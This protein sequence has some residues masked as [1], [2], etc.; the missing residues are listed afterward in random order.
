MDIAARPDDPAATAWLFEAKARPP[1]LTLP[2]LAATAAEALALADAPAEAG[3]LAAAFWPGP[4]TLVLRR[5]ERSRPW[6]LGGESS[7]IGLR[8]PDLALAAAFLSRTGPLAVTSANR[9]GRPPA[10]GRE[11]L[12]AVFGPSVAVYLVAA[13]GAAQDARGGGRPST[14]VDLSGSPRAS[15]RRAGTLARTQIDAVVSA[16]GLALEWVDFPA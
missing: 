16:S 2:V 3:P 13:G 9:S 11:E 5:G 6:D 12:I 1:G 14:V 4:L 15:F 7:T 10:T 8:V